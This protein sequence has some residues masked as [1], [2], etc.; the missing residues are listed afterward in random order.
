MMG[1]RDFPQAQHQ[2]ERGKGEQHH[3]QRTP[4]G[5]KHQVTADQWRD[6]RGDHGHQ[7]HQ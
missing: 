7:V 6:Q 1:F 5:N 3:E 4:A 2:H